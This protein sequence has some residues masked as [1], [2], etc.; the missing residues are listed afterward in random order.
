[1]SIPSIGSEVIQFY[2]D[3]TGQ[4]NPIVR[5]VQQALNQLAGYSELNENGNFNR[6]T[7][8]AIRDFQA[9]HHISGEGRINEQTIQVLNREVSRLERSNTNSQSTPPMAQESRRRQILEQRIQE[10]NVRAELQ[11]SLPTHY[12]DVHRA[13]TTVP[14]R[15][16]ANGVDVEVYGATPEELGLIQLTLE[17]LPRSHVESIPRIVVADTVAHGQIRRGANSISDRQA[18]HHMDGSRYRQ[19]LEHEGAGELFYRESGLGRLELTHAALQAALRRGHQTSGALLHESAHFANLRHHFTRGISP[20]DLGEITYTGVNNPGGDP[21]GPIP[22][23][24]ADAYMQY[25]QGR[26][27]DPAAL[28]TLR[29]VM[30]EIEPQH[31]IVEESD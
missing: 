12:T 21:R 23:R 13:M 17:R 15:V 31:T 14:Q 26:L 18:E 20:D 9:R 3:Q 28:S 2:P 30:G 5:D 7:E 27:R 25:F 10:P 24:F 19:R 11:R 1:M 4:T 16:R 22:E 6:E 8:D 29:R